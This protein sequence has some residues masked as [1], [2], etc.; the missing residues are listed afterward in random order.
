MAKQAPHGRLIRKIFEVDVL[1]CKKCGGE[2]K[3]IAFITQRPPPLSLT[4]VSVNEP[5][6]RYSDYIPPDDVYLRDEEYAY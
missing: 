4:T 5:D 2:M 3:V 1:R 6:N